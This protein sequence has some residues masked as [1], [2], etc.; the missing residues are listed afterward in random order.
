MM[1]SVDLVESEHGRPDTVS[2]DNR[3]EQQRPDPGAQTNMA[4]SMM[5]FVE[6]LLRL[7]IFATAQQDPLRMT[8][9]IS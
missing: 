8:T 2:V 7:S 3:D 1:D 9:Q 6:N 5:R 4:Y